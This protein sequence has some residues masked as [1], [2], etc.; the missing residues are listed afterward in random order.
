MKNKYEINY[1]QVA[2]EDLREILEYVM[3]DNPDYAISLLNKFDESIKH[4]LDFP[5]IG[6]TP[7]DNFIRKMNYRIICIDSYLVFYVFS[8]DVIEIR[9]IISGKRKYDYLF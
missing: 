6:F 4:L 5:L 9:R 2:E 1:L 3:I 8:N 7:K